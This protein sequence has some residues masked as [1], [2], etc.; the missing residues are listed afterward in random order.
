MQHPGGTHLKGG[1]DMSGG[2]DPL[3]TPLLP[4]NRSPVAA[5]FSSLDPTLSKND[6]FW[7]LWERFVKKLQN[8]LALQPKFGKISL[9]KPQN[10]DNFQFLLLQK[11]EK[12]KSQF[13]RP[14]FWPS[15]LDI[16]TPENVECPPCSNGSR[17]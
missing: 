6:K 3:F 12:R 4:L 16:P 17:C 10:V 13:F 2:Q 5:W 1:T 7:L 8:F 14:P 9:H 15:T 11:K